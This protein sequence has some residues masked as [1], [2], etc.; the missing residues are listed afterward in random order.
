M[1]QGD[2]CGPRDQNGPG[3]V[4]DRQVTDFESRA[5]AYLHGRLRLVASWPDGQG[6]LAWIR[7]PAVV[8]DL[9]NAVC[10]V[11][12]PDVNPPPI[13]GIVGIVGI[14]QSPGPMKT[15]GRRGYVISMFVASSRSFTCGPG[16]PAPSGSFPNRWLTARKSSNSVVRHQPRVRRAPGRERATIGARLVARVRPV[17]LAAEGRAATARLQWANLR[18]GVLRVLDELAYRAVDRGAMSV[19]RTDHDVGV[20]ELAQVRRGRRSRSR[21]PSSGSAGRRVRDLSRRE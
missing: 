18:P 20:V 17:L 12:Q 3:T 9:G 1:A 19:G 14:A 11:G 15:H 8:L 4:L 2:L 5:L 7:L 10:G 13:V 6:K 21:Y 16:R